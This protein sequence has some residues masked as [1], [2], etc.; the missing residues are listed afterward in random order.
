VCHVSGNELITCHNQLREQ[1]QIV[2]CTNEDKQALLQMFFSHH[3][4]FAL[5][6]SELGETDSVEH[7]IETVDNQPVRVSPRRLP[8]ALRTELEVLN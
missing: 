4:V 8:Y 3:Q 2:E 1:L 5:S 7:N 6:D